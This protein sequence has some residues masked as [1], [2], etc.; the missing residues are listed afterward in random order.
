MM[1][2]LSCFLSKGSLR[3]AFCSLC[4]AIWLSTLPGGVSVHLRWTHSLI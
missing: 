2:A 4:F 1:S 3:F